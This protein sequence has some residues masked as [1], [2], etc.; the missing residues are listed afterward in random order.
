[1]F[2]AAPIAADSLAKLADRLDV[3][4]AHGATFRQRRFHGRPRSDARDSLSRS[5]KAAALCA[6]V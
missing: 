6:L 2:V 4:D 3:I 5:A 1:V